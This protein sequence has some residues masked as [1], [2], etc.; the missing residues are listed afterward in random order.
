MIPANWLE[1]FNKHLTTLYGI[2]HKDAGASD[3]EL[4][5]YTD[6]EPR[7]AAIVY[8]EDYDIERID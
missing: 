4:L 8:G 6:L 3:E 5:R 2:N 1:A 7:E